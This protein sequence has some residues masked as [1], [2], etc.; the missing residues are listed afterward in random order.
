MKDALA[1]D[2]VEQLARVAHKW[3]PLFTMLGVQQHLPLL[4]KIEHH[5]EDNTLRPA[6]ETVIQ[7]AELI[8][9]A[10]QELLKKNKEEK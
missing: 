9:V 6:A 1:A 8:I 3:V 2:N 10:L 7:E 5:V 4:R